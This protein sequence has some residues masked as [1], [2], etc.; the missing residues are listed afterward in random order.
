MPK[1]NRPQ[2]S[3]RFVHTRYYS[4]YAGSADEAYKVFRSAVD[5]QLFTDAITATSEF[6]TRIDPVNDFTQKSYYWD[7]EE[8]VWVLVDD[9]PI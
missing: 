9:R 8:E 7:D 4:V 6:I 2:Q 1:K 3:Y 5:D